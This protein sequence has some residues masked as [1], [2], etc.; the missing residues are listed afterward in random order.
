MKIVHTILGCLLLVGYFLLNSCHMPN[1]GIPIYVKVDSVNVKDGS[2]NLLTHNVTDVWV[3]ANSTNV[4]AFG[5]P[6]NFPVLQENNIRFVV[7]A[8]IKE[9]GQSGVRVTYPFYST[10]TF[11][12]S[13]T[14]GSQYSHIAS[15]KYITGAQ[16]ALNENFDAGNDFTGDT[17]VLRPEGGRCATISVSAS[18]SLKL[19]YQTMSKDLPEGLEIWLELD[20]KCD[21]PFYAGFFGAFS[22]STAVRVPVVFLAEKAEWSHV[23][24]KLSDYVSNLR[25]DTYSVYFEAL[26]PYGTT[27]G[28]VYI[29]N[30]KLIHL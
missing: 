3:E 4:G 19:M 9:S 1:D 8:G 24:I 7:S 25:A 13:G 11:S 26:R 18:D 10:D 16:F 29:D 23:Y 12:I 21:V 6:C 30:V 28:T 27:G 17:V 5:L 15:F 2:G 14:R 22:G 20:Y